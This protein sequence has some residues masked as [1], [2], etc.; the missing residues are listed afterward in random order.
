MPAGACRSAR[1]AAQRRAATYKCALRD[2]G[3]DAFACRDLSTVRLTIG[4]AG[5]EAAFRRQHFPIWD[6]GSEERG[7]QNHKPYIWTRTT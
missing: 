2:F 5:F 1:R 6:L 3:L 7:R 4:E